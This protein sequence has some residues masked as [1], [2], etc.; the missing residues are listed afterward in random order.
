[1]LLSVFRYRSC[2]FPCYRAQLVTVCPAVRSNRVTLRI[3]RTRDQVQAALRRLYCANATDSIITDGSV[4][5]KVCGWSDEQTLIAAVALDEGRTVFT[6]PRL[7]QFV[8]GKADRH[9]V[10]IGPN[11]HLDFARALPAAS[12]TH[13]NC[14]PNGDLVVMDHGVDFVTRRP[15]KEGEIL[16][17][18]Y[19]TTE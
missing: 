12:M 15:V 19:N 5:A 6:V 18:D 14:S 7:P 3:G 13:H 9:S 4:V 2:T 1:M 8:L 17:F 11:E 10:Q 16:S